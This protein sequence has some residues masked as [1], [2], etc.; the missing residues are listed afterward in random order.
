[1]KGE[2]AKGVVNGEEVGRRGEIRGSRG[3]RS[4]KNLKYVLIGYETLSDRR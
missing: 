2:E 1:M 4:L 3:G